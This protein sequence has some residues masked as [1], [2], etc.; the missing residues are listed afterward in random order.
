MNV[1]LCDVTDLFMDVKSRIVDEMSFAWIEK[2][3]K[4]LEV[5]STSKCVMSSKNPLGE[6]LAM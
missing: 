2:R 5:A 3:K 6:R 4:L 1:A